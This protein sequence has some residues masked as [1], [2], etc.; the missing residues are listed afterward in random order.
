MTAYAGGLRISKL[1]K[2]KVSDIDGR[3]MMIRIENGKG[4]KDRYTIL[5]ARLLEELRSYWKIYRPGYWL[6]PN[7]KTKRH[8]TKIFPR[9]AF[10]QA[11]RKAGIKKNVTFHSLRHYVECYIMVSS[12]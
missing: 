5:S 11:K 8:I 12:P 2:L 10:D 6:F 3:R 9:R 7:K 4:V 1:I